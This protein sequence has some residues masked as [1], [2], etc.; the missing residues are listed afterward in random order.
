MSSAS[1]ENIM[2]G[3]AVTAPSIPVQVQVGASSD[4]VIVYDL[5]DSDTWTMYLLNNV[6][7]G[8]GNAVVGTYYDQGNGLMFQNVAVP[9]GATVLGARLLVM[10]SVTNS[11]TVVN[12]R[13]IG[14]LELDAATFSNIADYIARRG[15]DVGGGDN[16]KRTVAQVS[17][18]S[19]VAF[20]AGVW[21]YSPDISIIIQEIVDQTGWA[22]GNNIALFFDDH[23]SR[24]TT[25]VAHNRNFYA[26]DQAGNVS[27]PILQI[28]YELQSMVY[29]MLVGC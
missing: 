22:S 6:A 29:M 15:T 8:L 14:D 23:E 17:W 12:S 2:N 9:P 20:T 24:S 4:D 13:I 10:A 5:N 27:G 26:Y 3:L 11:T 25:G 19:I 28:V 7:G 18:D 16:T 1:F 21:Y